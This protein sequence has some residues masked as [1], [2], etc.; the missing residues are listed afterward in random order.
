MYDAYV[1]GLIFITVGSLV[2]SILAFMGKE[3]I[4]NDTYIK[5]SKETR[6]K[7]NK[8]AYCVQTGI[9]FM[10]LFVVSLC[11]ALRFILHIKW[12]TYISLFFLV[13]G[14]IYTIVSHYK[15]KK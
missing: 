8:K 10:F 9:I 6:E 5:A 15:L 3:I 7:M 13:I 4:L 1:W 12:F 14:I 11:N 2:F